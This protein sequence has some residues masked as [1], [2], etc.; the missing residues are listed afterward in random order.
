MGCGLKCEGVIGHV[1]VET[2][3]V[4]RLFNGNEHFYTSCQEEAE[5]CGYD[6]EGI[7]GHVVV[8]PI[9]GMVPM[10]RL[11][12]EDTGDHFYTS[13]EEEAEASGLKREG[14]VGHVFGDPQA[15]FTMPIHRMGNGADH[16]YTTCD[17][18]AENC[19]YDKEGVLGWILK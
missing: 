18:E 16:F 15:D 5:N 8:P 1:L 6:C 3:P 4:H 2:K 13:C 9:G 12:N 7:V 17:D 14:H 10:H 19:G 11:F